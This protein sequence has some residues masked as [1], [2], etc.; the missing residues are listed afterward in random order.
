LHGALVAHLGVKYPIGDKRMHTSPTGAVRTTLPHL[1]ALKLY[2]AGT[3]ATQDVAMLLQ[4]N[5]Q[6]GTL[7]LAAVRDVCQRYM[8]GPRLERLLQELGLS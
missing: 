5:E 2:T 8:L 3:Q 1:I 4:R 6:S 7:D